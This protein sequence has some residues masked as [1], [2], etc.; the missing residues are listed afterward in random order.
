MVLF[1][2]SYSITE[3]KQCVGVV[4]L[5]GKVFVSFESAFTLAVIICVILYNYIISMKFIMTF[6]DKGYD[7]SCTV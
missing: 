6:H 5:D 1:K 7:I 4:I 3:V 2:G